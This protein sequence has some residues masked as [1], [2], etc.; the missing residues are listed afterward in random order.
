MASSITTSKRASP[1]ASSLKSEIEDIVSTTNKTGGGAWLL[2]KA[3]NE[4]QA[5]DILK[6]LKMNQV[7]DMDKST[8]EAVHLEK[9]TGAGGPLY[10]DNSD[11]NSSNMNSSSTSN[12]TGSSS[13]SPPSH[14]GIAREKE[15]DGDAPDTVFRDITGGKSESSS[16]GS[17][18]K[19][20]KSSQVA[21]PQV[22][23]ASTGGHSVETNGPLYGK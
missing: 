14:D 4:T 20:Q 10:D 11:S 17:D 16:S 15:N 8:I 9:E 2:I 1:I 12:S 6:E 19:A 23:S 13:S 21:S 3:N 18:N 22:E 7:F 5:S